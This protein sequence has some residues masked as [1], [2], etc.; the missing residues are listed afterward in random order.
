MAS[1]V[2]DSQGISMMD[3][4]EEGRTLIGPYY[5]EE[6]RRLDPIVKKKGGKLTQSVLLF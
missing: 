3:Y 4:L 1:I 5:A 2:W 6:R